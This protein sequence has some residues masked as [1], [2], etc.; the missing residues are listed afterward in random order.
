MSKRKGSIVPYLFIVYCL[1]WCVSLNAF[2]RDDAFFFQ[3]RPWKSRGHKWFS[4][5]SVAPGLRVA[6]GGPFSGPQQDA[7]EVEEPVALRRSLLRFPA[8]SG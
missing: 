7:R 1:G 3:S 4:A 2:P 5:E 8:D 6:G